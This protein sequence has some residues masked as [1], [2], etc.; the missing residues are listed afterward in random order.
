M[1]RGELSHGEALKNLGIKKSP[2]ELEGLTPVILTVEVSDAESLPV[3]SSLNEYMV[4]VCSVLHEP[5]NFKAQAIDP[6]TFSKDLNLFAKKPD[7]IS[8]MLSLGF[9]PKPAKFLFTGVAIASLQ[10]KSLSY[11]S[12][13]Q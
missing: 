9:P 11:Y 6:N 2:E 8:S 5:F 7:L 13:S 3:G 10:L 12:A 4:E 1:L